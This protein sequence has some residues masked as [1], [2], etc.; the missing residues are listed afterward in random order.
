MYRFYNTLNTANCFYFL[1]L[2]INRRVQYFLLESGNG[3]FDVI[4][5]TALIFLAKPLD[6]ETKAEY[7]LTLK[8]ADQGV[9]QLWSVVSIHVVVLDINDNPPEFQ[10]H[11]YN[12][13]V[14]EN[15]T[16]GSEV[17]HVE[18]ASLDV[19]QNAQI[20]YSINAGNDDGK[21]SID[22]TSGIKKQILQLL[23]QLLLIPDPLTT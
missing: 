8:G 21:F 15:A 7:L 18:A 4:R 19:G 16:V 9:P 5:E 23:V 17:I 10:F 13:T 22:N 11:F 6:R 12:A 20:M 14:P 1:L 3:H 2:G